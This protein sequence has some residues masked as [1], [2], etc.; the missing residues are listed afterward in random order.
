[1]AS[2]QHELEMF[3]TLEEKLHRPDTKHSLEN[4]S[5][6]L[7]D[8]FVE[9]GSSGGVYDKAETVGALAAEPVDEAAPAV[10]AYD[11]AIRSIAADAVLLT[12]R[13][14]RTSAGGERRALRSSIWKLIG[15]RWQMVFHQGTIIPGK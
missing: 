12:Y 7:A 14:V 2:H 15:G 5:A 10:R 3:R 11:Y 4:V 9:F 13:S 6:L 1:M 8:D